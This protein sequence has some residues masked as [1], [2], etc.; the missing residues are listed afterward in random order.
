M[1]TAKKPAASKA[2]P[3][4]RRKLGVVAREQAAVKPTPKPRPS[5]A[6]KAAPAP[7]PKV[8]GFRAHLFAGVAFSPYAL[9]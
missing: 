9:A 6:K 1:T 4:T 2:A 8:S 5:R 7:R 3:V